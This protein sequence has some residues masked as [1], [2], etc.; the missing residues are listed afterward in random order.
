VPLADWGL[1]PFRK[2]SYTIISN[3]PIFRRFFSG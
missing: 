1:T 3:R 2:I